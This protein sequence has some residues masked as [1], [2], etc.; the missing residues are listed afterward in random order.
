VGSVSRQ[1]VL[2]LVLAASG[3][4]AVSGQAGRDG[5]NNRARDLFAQA[6]H[7]E[8]AAGNPAA[9]LELY[10]QVLAAGP[11]RALAARA[12]LRIGICHER[13]GNQAAAAAAFAKIVSSYADQPAVVAEAR[14]RAAAPGAAGQP[15]PA[16]A[17]LQAVQIYSGNDLHPRASPSLDGRYLA[18]VDYSTEGDVGVMDLTTGSR[19][20]LTR[21]ADYLTGFAY[22]PVFSPDGTQIVYAWAGDRNTALRVVDRT[23][24]AP[25]VLITSSSAPVDYP[26]AWSPDGRRLALNLYADGQSRIAIATI[27]NGSIAPATLQ[28]LKSTAWQ[29]ADVGGFSPDGRFLVYSLVPADSQPGGVF[30]IAVDGSGESKVADGR[31]PAWTPD[32]RSVVFVSDRSG[33][34]DLWSVGIAEGKPSA[35]PE[36]LKSNIGDIS[37]LG[38]ARDGT[39][40]YGTRT[41]GRDIVTASLDPAARRVGAPVPLTQTLVG[42]NSGAAW[43]PD[44]RRIA[45][46]RGGD[47]IVV[48]TIA[49]GEERLVPTKLQG[50]VVLQ[51]IRWFPDGRAVLLQDRTGT[52]RRGYK[53]VE[54]ET[55]AQ[56]ILFDAPGGTALAPF[57]L[58]PDGR[59]VYYFR[60]GEEEVGGLREITLV[61]RDLQTGI[62]TALHR[63]KASVGGVRLAV[64]PDGSRLAFK[65]AGETVILSMPAAGGAATEVR[66]GDSL[67]DLLAW[68]RDGRFLIGDS[69]EATGNNTRDQLRLY[70]LPV[71]GG[72]PVAL[73]H[74]APG[75]IDR[76][77]VSAADTTLLMSVSRQ[78]KELWVVRNLLRQGSTR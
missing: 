78:N 52:G 27:D 61:R 34:S 30:V 68:T 76:L 25:R 38:F 42:S 17:S 10:Q 77:S 57:D 66:R 1:V 73:D 3:L 60:R 43:S 19:R 24:G 28:P 74:V 23:G 16:G 49:T 21:D 67:P 47:T 69:N 50:A 48:R 33:T 53:K 2:A 56:Q 22:N 70:L 44:G 55:G 36:R 18:F 11:D 12:D 14:A 15:A 54:V 5:Q 51:G 72:A 31:S 26:F 75:S 29:K 58:S 40:F 64:S 13:L 6:M 62:E 45:F 9:A 20:M 39:F 59:F 7:Q 35:L 41:L 65:P 46:F 4:V 32:G 8:D 63:N 37:N 71:D